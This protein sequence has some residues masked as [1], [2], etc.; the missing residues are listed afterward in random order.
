ML[1]YGVCDTFSREHF[2]YRVL[3]YGFVVFTALLVL[4]LLVFWWQEN[5]EAAR[6]RKIAPP[7]I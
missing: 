5:R 1:G 3:A 2:M 6:R 7:K 4:V